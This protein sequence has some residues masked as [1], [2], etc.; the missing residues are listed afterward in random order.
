MSFMI[1]HMTLHLFM[2]HRIFFGHNQTQPSS[3]GCF[4]ALS[5]ASLS[6]SRALSHYALYNKL[7]RLCMPTRQTLVMWSRSSSPLSPT[8]GRFLSSGSLFSL[9]GLN[10]RGWSLSTTHHRPSDF[11]ALSREA[12]CWNLLKRALS[13]H[14]ISNLGLSSLWWSCT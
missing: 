9:S 5:I 1:S 4:I 14:H 11:K 2:I 10:S 8:R 7:L 12:L 3:L 6:L 13:L